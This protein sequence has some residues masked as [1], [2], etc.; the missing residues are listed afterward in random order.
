MDLNPDTLL[1]RLSNLSIGEI[2]TEQDA[3]RSTGQFDEDLDG[4]Y[5][6]FIEDKAT[7][8][9]E[10]AQKAPVSQLAEDVI[11]GEREG[12]YSKDF[13][14]SVAVPEMAR[15][16]KEESE[17]GP[18]QNV[19]E[20][21]KAIVSDIPGAV[22]SFGHAL[23]GMGKGVSEAVNAGVIGLG[24]LAES[25]PDVRR[26]MQSRA[27]ARA[28]SGLESATQGTVRPLSRFAQ[29]AI[30]GDTEAER[31]LADLAAKVTNN[32][33]VRAGVEEEA[34]K[35]GD[36]KTWWETYSAPYKAAADTLAGN[37]ALAKMIDVDAD[38]LK[39]RY[40]IKLEAEDLEAG[41][42]ISEAAM[43]GVME[44]LPY[45]TGVSIGA[46]WAA[47]TGRAAKA[48][49]VLKGANASMLEKGIATIQDVAEK[50]LRKLGGPSAPVIQVTKGLETKADEVAKIS[51]DTARYQSALRDVRMKTGAVTVE[52]GNAIRQ[53][54]AKSGAGIETGVLTAGIALASGADPQE[55]LAAGIS[56]Y[57]G[58]RILGGRVGAT[59]TGMGLERAGKAL[60]FAMPGEG[61]RRALIDFS[62]DYK[63]IQTT[64]VGA[65]FGAAAALPWA[66]G[67]ENPEEAQ[68]ALSIGAAFGALGAAKGRFVD[69]GSREILKRRAGGAE[70]VGPFKPTE[71]LG[72][73]AGLDAANA[74]AENLLS[75]TGLG[76]AQ[77]GRQL[78]RSLGGE[79][80]YFATAENMA[81]EIARVTNNNPA[82]AGAGDAQGV[83]IP[84]SEN[85]TGKPLVFSTIGADGRSTGH[86]LFHLLAAHI[87][88]TE[89]GR[90]AMDGVR[91]RV[92]KIFDAGFQDGKVTGISDSLRQFAEFYNREG[93]LGT[94]AAA[95]MAPDANLNDA[96]VQRFWR[97]MLDEVAAEH[98]NVAF[99][100]LPAGRLGGSKEV[101]T[102]LSRAFATLVDRA[103][104]IQRPGF[105]PGSPVV[106]SEA[107]KIQPDFDLVSL[108]ENGLYSGALE[109]N[110]TV[111][112]KSFEASTAAPTG[113]APITTV[114][115]TTAPT[116]TAPVATAPRTVDVGVLT[117][118]PVS[119]TTDRSL[120]NRTPPQQ[121]TAESPQPAETETKG[122]GQKFPVPEEIPE[123][124]PAVSSPVGAT[125][126]SVPTTP[127]GAVR[128]T[129]TQAARTNFEAPLTESERAEA[130]K[131]Q[132]DA[133]ALPAVEKV[134]SFLKALGGQKVGVPIAEVSYKGTA[135]GDN[136]TR[137][138]RVAIYGREGST[139]LA[140]DIDRVNYNADLLFQWAKENNRPLPYTGIDDPAFTRDVQTY[141]RNHAE[142]RRGSGE[143]LYIE[144]KPSTASGEPVAK[145]TREQEQFI[146]IAMGQEAKAT[147]TPRNAAALGRQ[148]ATAR[149]SGIEPLPFGEGSIEPNALRNTL[150][151]EGAPIDQIGADPD[152]TRRQANPNDRNSALM[153]M[154][155]RGI[156]DFKLTGQS[157]S[158]PNQSAYE[159]S[160][161]PAATES[162]N[163]KNW[164]TGSK[165]VDESGAPLRVYHGTSKDKIFSSFTESAKGSWFTTD[166]ETASEYAKNNDSQR[167]VTDYRGRLEEKNTASRVI[168]AYLS[169]KN[170]MV[171]DGP[172]LEKWR[173]SENYVSANKQLVRQAQQAG[174]D[175][176]AFPG[177]IFVS[178][179][180]EQVKSALSPTFDPKNP[181]RFMPAANRAPNENIREISKEYVKAQRIPY[182]P[183]EKAISVNEE[184]A[185]RIADYYDKSVDSPNDPKVKAAYTALANETVQQWR[186]FEKQGYVAEPWK[187]EG[188]PYKDSAE[189]MADVRDNKHIYYF[190]TEGGFGVGGITPEMRASNPLL[191]ESGVT[192]GT[193]KNVPVNDVFR[194]VHDIVGHGAHG[195]EFGPKGELNAYIEHSRMF[196]N[197][198]KPALAAETLAQ[199]SWVNYGAHLRRPDGS[200]PKKGE[201]G[202]IPPAERRFADQKNLAIPD[203]FLREVDQYAEKSSGNTVGASVVAKGLPQY[204]P[205][206]DVKKI[207]PEIERLKGVDFAEDGGGTYTLDGSKHQGGGL[208]IPL[209]SQNFNRNAITPEGITKFID[210][211]ADKLSD[212][213]RWG[214]YKFKNSDTL[215]VDLSIVAKPEDTQ[216]ALLVGRAL[217]QE[218]LYDLTNYENVQTGASGNNT[219]PLNAAQFKQIGE[220]LFNGGVPFDVLEEARKNNPEI[221]DKID[222]ELG[223]NPLETPE[224]IAIRENQI[225]RSGPLAKA[226]VSSKQPFAGQAL[227]VLSEE[228]VKGAKYT[229]TKISEAPKTNGQFMPA[230]KATA[231]D[232]VRDGDSNSLP[233]HQKLV[234]GKPAFDKKG[235]IVPLKVPYDLL[236][237][238]AL[239]QA[240]G[241]PAVTGVDEFISALPFKL[242]NPEKDLIREYAASGAISAAADK[243]ADRT[244]EYLRNPEIAAGKGWYSRMRE[245]L[246]RALGDLSE[247]MAQLL[248]AT[249]ARTPVD[250]NFLQAMDALEQIA[251]GKY[252]ALVDRVVEFEN[253]GS[254]SFKQA[255]TSKGDKALRES[256]FQK[257]YDAQVEYLVQKDYKGLLKQQAKDALKR[258]QKATGQDAKDLLAEGKFLTDLSR[259][260][261]TQM[262]VDPAL[263]ASVAES[264]LE[265]MPRRSN[266]KKFNANTSQVRNVIMG[267]WLEKTKAPKTPNFAGN[268]TGRTLEATIDVWAARF[269]RSLLYTEGQWRIQPASETGVSNGDFALG[270]L[271]FRETAKRVEMNPDDLQAVLWFAEKDNWEKNGWTNTVGAGKTSFDTMFNTFFPENAEPRK[272]A[273]VKA[274]I[275]AT[276]ESK[277]AE[278]IAQEKEKAKS[279]GMTYARWKE[280]QK[281]RDAE[282]KKKELSDDDLSEN[283]YDNP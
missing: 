175:G 192:F 36:D 266:G 45:V 117:P 280:I 90:K 163:F 28:L 236:E 197:A 104:G 68:G 140:F 7:K 149:A 217:G 244:Q 136:T 254:D 103:A 189:M 98:G 232:V 279:L 125:E 35:K 109:L 114:T 82:Y 202:Y 119:L 111:P 73:D 172:T 145:L 214:L 153:R 228:I 275:E 107:L 174:H 240:T 166:P 22:S 143:P 162:T 271:I 106:S 52:L 167:I 110:D 219:L 211:H 3:L 88:S 205:R 173:R 248:G 207:V 194:V 200:L 130:E 187:G 89:A 127:A 105:N 134:M 154:A 62:K 273:D 51:A 164:F 34:L 178:F 108:I 157:T 95:A 142:S 91:S 83:F 253:V 30:P 226:S 182:R 257:G 59:L 268:L 41:K 92:A 261:P 260:T 195:Y 20:G 262:R 94:S 135:P 216:N 235:R 17:K 54:A 221:A 277:K 183:H 122:T 26:D 56:G 74:Q 282:A 129:E 50:G 201:E 155:A 146:S 128:G 18:L 159:A 141:V 203:E 75:Q 223:G 29:W 121:P 32:T 270:Q 179:K 43:F 181:A 6:S 234:D 188:Q 171:I 249:S 12:R 65:G 1:E 283:S 55:A 126:P 247:T 148:A 4:V 57:I 77:Q 87:E 150:R 215:S 263:L 102:A 2:E 199:N 15:R 25:N 190:E 38:T 85:T 80:V 42:S 152:P 272:F 60:Q 76:V 79:S 255:S 206:P 100:R 99:N 113:T 72:L 243:A 131:I 193:A 66:L 63:P 242:T 210:S 276:R 186:A 13:I 37:G 31:T 139:F 165:V 267:V 86:E 246:K 169:I 10:G 147:A 208:V 168:P 158:I 96:G 49:V 84:A 67:A 239:K 274:E 264:A 64:L 16:R 69:F 256:L 170:P 224:A 137:S 144:G 230:V 184:L 213:V 156:Q 44:A 281:Q 225:E 81:Q 14:D 220:A 160:F 9:I 212:S 120:G 241:G 138:K 252:D 151:N 196:S 78:S 5:S 238:P 115:P 269:L 39:N 118:V 176:L 97:A 233:V 23:Y 24:S 21:A 33:T 133:K 278:K 227:N 191:A 48:R 231:G 218:S 265:L 258:A 251:S 19:A 198:A 222:A 209:A 204:M 61:I 245:G 250:E 8:W 259:T 46:K 58:R 132:P 93:I 40:G 47:R 116:A 71:N 180:P 123:N 27:A 124:Q 229:P 11:A 53:Q 70:S 237:A 161:M 101:S 185:K 112:D 177:G